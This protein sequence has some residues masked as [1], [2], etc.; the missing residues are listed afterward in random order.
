MSI[1]SQ[2]AQRAIKRRRQKQLMT[3]GL[4]ALGGLILVAMT[5]FLIN[6]NKPASKVQ[7][8]VK[9][10]PRLKVDKDQVDLGKVA[11]GNTVSVDFTLSNTGDQPLKLSEQPYIDVIEGC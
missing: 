9:G 2:K 5:A 1:K 10:S 7:V 6:N 8:D 3:V 11:L 4:L